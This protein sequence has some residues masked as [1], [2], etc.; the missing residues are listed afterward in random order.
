[1]AR[2]INPHSRRQ[3]HLAKTGQAADFVSIPAA[4]NQQPAPAWPL[5]GEPAR[6]ELDMWQH[7][8]TTPQ[9]TMWASMSIERVIAR[10]VMVTCLAEQT[11][12]A[13]L[14][15]EVRQLED[16][17]GLTPVSLRKLQWKI[18]HQDNQPVDASQSEESK[19][20]WAQ[21]LDLDRH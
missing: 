6:V 7:L 18:E 21:I 20:R 10:Y 9:A 13:G 2:P 17:L 5:D 15:A 1:M 12:Q 19:E 4:G 16:R 8:W 11:Q 3:R 14:L